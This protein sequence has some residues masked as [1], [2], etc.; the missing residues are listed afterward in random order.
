MRNI[1]VTIDKEDQTL[2]LLYSLP[3]LYDHFIDTMLYDI[4][5]IS[6]SDVKDTLQYIKSKKIFLKL[7]RKRLQRLKSCAIIS[8]SDYIMGVY[9]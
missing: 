5:F 7:I 6:V 1:G 2:I 4:D 9:I 3:L 8:A